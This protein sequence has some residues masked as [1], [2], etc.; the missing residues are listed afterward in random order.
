MVVQMQHTTMYSSTQ[1]V[2]IGINVTFNKYSELP[3]HKYFPRV[4]YML[5]VKD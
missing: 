1:E 2:L 5:D 4:H 3:L